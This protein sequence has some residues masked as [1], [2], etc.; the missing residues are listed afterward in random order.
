MPEA[1]V[2]EADRLLNEPIVVEHPAGRQIGLRFTNRTMVEVERQFGSVQ[3]F[4]NQL[5]EVREK[6]LSAP[7]YTFLTKTLDA[8][9]WDDP[10]VIRE[11]RADAM[12]RTQFASYLAAVTRAYNQ[13]WPEPNGETPD[14]NSNGAQPKR[15]GAKSHG[16]R[17]STGQS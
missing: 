15:K 3:A 8:L 17:G 11:N 14:P 10:A 9:L 7:L 1:R 5:R 13:Y 16:R 2:T 12:E 6:A 4:E